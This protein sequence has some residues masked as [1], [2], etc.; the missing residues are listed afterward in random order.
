MKDLFSLIIFI[1][2][3]FILYH[4]FKDTNNKYTVKV[5]DQD[6]NLVDFV[7]TDFGKQKRRRASRASRASSRRK[8]SSKNK[9]ENKCREII[10]RKYNRRFDSIRPDFLKSPYT[11]RN[12]ELDMYNEELKLAIEYNG[13]QHYKYTPFFHKNGEYDFEK[14]KLHDEF[15]HAICKRKGIRL[16]SIP[17]TIPMSEMESWIQ[18]NV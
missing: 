2:G 5:G 17:Y 10:E 14:Q 9:S 7:L 12:L 18:R 11:G 8:K 6:L 4:L 13:I 16:I 15:K 1:L 3:I